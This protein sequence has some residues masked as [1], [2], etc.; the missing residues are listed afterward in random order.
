MM[1]S[2]SCGAGEPVSEI[3]RQTH[4]RQ[5]GGFRGRQAARR[6]RH[7]RARHLAVG[8]LHGHAQAALADR[9]ERRTPRNDR[10][11]DAGVDE[12]R[13]ERAAHCPGADHAHAHGAESSCGCCTATKI[14]VSVI[15]PPPQPL[16][17]AA[18]A[19]SVCLT[20]AAPTSSSRLGD[21]CAKALAGEMR[22]HRMTR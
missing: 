19:A 11:F 15:Y 2:N 14:D 4:L 1:R 21:T 9:I 7:E 20:R 16:V 18:R 13:R 5:C 3:D 12:V 10:D 22:H 17:E 6:P 8:R